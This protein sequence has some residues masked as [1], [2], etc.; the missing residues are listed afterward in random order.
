MSKRW[1]K[2]KRQK[3]QDLLKNSDQFS[4]SS[5][6][7]NWSDLKPD[8]SPQSFGKFTLSAC[9]TNITGQNETFKPAEEMEDRFNEDF[10]ENQREYAAIPK[11]GSNINES[12]W[13]R[14]DQNIT[15]RHSG[16]SFGAYAQRFNDSNDI[17]QLYSH[18][19]PAPRR[20]RVPFI[21]MKEEASPAPSNK[22]LNKRVYDLENMIL[23]LANNSERNK[24]NEHHHEPTAAMNGKKLY[25]V[26]KVLDR[27]LTSKGKEEYLLRWKDSWVPKECLQCDVLL[28]EFEDSYNENK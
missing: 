19:S 22:E 15:F 5:K 4:Q 3:A 20:N 16:I 8:D 7:F 1:A 21:D 10:L 27:R 17:R 9:I 23:E 14:L 26:E 18:K 24:E 6:S 11:R 13:T 12:E 25:A 28:K 2:E